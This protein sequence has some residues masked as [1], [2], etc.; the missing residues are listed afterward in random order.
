MSRSADLTIAGRFCGPASSGNGGYTAG[1]LAERVPGSTER[2]AVEVRLRQPPPLDVA[3]NVERVDDGALL[4]LGGARIAE[5][6]AV[7][8]DLEPVEVVSIEAAREA[9]TRYVGL[10][11]HPFPRCFACG[12]DRAEGDGLRIFPGPIDDA[13]GEA[14]KVAADGSH[15]ASGWV[16]HEGLAESSDLRD[17]LQRVGMGVA[18]AAL[19]CVGGW[20]GGIGERR[21]VLG[22]MTAQVDDLPLVH[23]PHVVV[24][25]SRGSEGRKTFT[26][27]TLYDS[28][29]RIVGR[30]QHT[31]IAID[32][33]AFS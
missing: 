4:L 1:S 15:V 13:V 20:A 9:A 30:A 17:G 12:P 16:P 24:G 23:E 14:A 21:M 7:Q 26:A 25:T 3:M 27:S 32:P 28:D 8:V 6:R 10:S 22:S 2:Q 31:W 33:S 11:L 19:D 29:G 5:A 18:W